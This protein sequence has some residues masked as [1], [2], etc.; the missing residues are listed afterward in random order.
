M[1]FPGYK[2]DWEVT[3]T[4]SIEYDCTVQPSFNPGTWVCAI[5]PLTE[6]KQ[7]FTGIQLNFGDPCNLDP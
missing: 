4:C 3:Y 7:E 6:V 2:K 1:F 5:D